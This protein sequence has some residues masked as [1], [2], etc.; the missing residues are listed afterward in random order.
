[1]RN[2]NIWCC[3][4]R[5][6][7]KSGVIRQKI[8]SQNGMFQESKAR[9]I[10]RKTNISYPLI[11]KRTSILLF[12]KF[13]VLCFPETLILRFSLLPYYR[14]NGRTKCNLNYGPSNLGKI[15]MLNPITT[16]LGAE[17]TEV[18]F[19]NDL[20]WSPDM[21][22]LQEFLNLLKGHNIHLQLPSLTLQKTY[23]FVMMY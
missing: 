21:I 14:Q 20:L 5:F 9:Q 7:Y 23:I 15:L 13:G 3:I 22:S 11:R 8:E 1:M 4:A 18:L 12:E 16:D 6:T 17:E 10:F 2:K 19:M